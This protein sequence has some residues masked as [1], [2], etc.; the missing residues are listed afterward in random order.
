M[1]KEQVNYHNS[2]RNSISD[3]EKIALCQRWKASNLSLESFC[4]EHGVAKSS[5][6]TWCKKFD[7]N[8]AAKATRPNFVPLL[9]TDKKIKEQEKISMELTLNNG[10]ILHLNL[11]PTQAV[12]L[13]QELSHATTT[14]R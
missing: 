10:A 9:H 11:S 7:L 4:K 2:S 5:L 1:S 13:I 8:S 12:A 14:V 6:Y 3:K